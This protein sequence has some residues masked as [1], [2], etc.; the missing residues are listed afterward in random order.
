M[1]FTREL[2][3]KLSW[4]RP[5][6]SI[7]FVMPQ[8][9]VCISTMSALWV[10]ISSFSM[11]E[12]EYR[13]RWVGECLSGPWFWGRVQVLK[14]E[15]TWAWRSR[16]CVLIFGVDNHGSGNRFPSFDLELLPERFD[17]NG[18]SCGLEPSLSCRVWLPQMQK[19]QQLLVGFFQWWACQNWLL[20]PSALHQRRITNLPTTWLPCAQT[21][22]T[23]DA[24]I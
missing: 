5:A 2:K 3:G 11:I 19:Q 17:S 4:H 6:V 10:K 12:L 1:K 7:C 13:S 24:D 9:G 22:Y 18:P 23:A 15:Q 16:E 8:A 20:R 21:S 14:F